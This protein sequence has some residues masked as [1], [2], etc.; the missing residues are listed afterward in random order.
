MLICTCM[1]MQT[2]LDDANNL[3]LHQWGLIDAAGNKLK[4][5][6]QSNQNLREEVRAVFLYSNAQ[7]SLDPL[8]ELIFVVVL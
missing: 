5:A 8:G 7:A 1:Q 2:E 4:S 3:A 6:M